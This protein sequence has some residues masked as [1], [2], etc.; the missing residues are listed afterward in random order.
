MHP[1]EN[2]SIHLS[3]LKLIGIDV[4]TGNGV[5]D[6]ATTIILVIVV[7]AGLILYRRHSIAKPNNRKAPKSN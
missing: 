2:L 5:L 1:T 7:F 4:D 3:I 6:A